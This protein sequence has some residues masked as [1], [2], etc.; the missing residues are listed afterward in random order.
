L[1]SL[2]PIPLK[3]SDQQEG[4]QEVPP[5]RRTKSLIHPLAALLLMVIDALWTMADWATMA[6]IFT[7][8]LSFLAV[9]LPTFFIQKHMNGDSTGKAMAVSAFLGILAAVPT[10]IMGTT[11]GAIALGLSGLRSLRWGK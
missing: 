4:R 7:I 3:S 8:P 11:V 1:T 9:F 6:W 10:P 2:T 5:A